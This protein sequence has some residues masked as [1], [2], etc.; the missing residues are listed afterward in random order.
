MEVTINIKQSYGRYCSVIYCNNNVAPYGD[1]FLTNNKNFGSSVL[2]E[3]NI[4]MS[5]DLF[6][7]TKDISICFIRSNLQYHIKL[8]E[9]PCIFNISLSK[10]ELSKNGKRVIVKFINS[11]FDLLHIVKSELLYS[12]TIAIPYFNVSKVSECPICLNDV[13]KNKNK[14]ITKCGHIFHINCIWNYLKCNN[15]I[16]TFNCVDC[17]HQNEMI[18]DSFKC[19]ICRTLL[20]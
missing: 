3:F 10:H 20:E 12:K 8:I 5:D 2:I 15:H 19:P 17:F 13:I 1:Y 7:R 4:N 18:T 14:Y 11:Y 6:I 16:T 9:N